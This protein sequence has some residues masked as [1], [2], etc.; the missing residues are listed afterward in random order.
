M[1]VFVLVEDMK[2]GIE[3]ILVLRNVLLLMDMHITHASELKND[4]KTTQKNG[5]NFCPSM[6]TEHSAVE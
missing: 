3:S 1:F 2:F 5:R 4:E 6:K